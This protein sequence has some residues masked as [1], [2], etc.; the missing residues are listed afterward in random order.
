MD[1]SFVDIVN[2]FGLQLQALTLDP[3]KPTGLCAMNIYHCLSMVA[4]GSKDKNLAGFSQALGFDVGNLDK[5]LQKSAARFL[6]QNEYGC[7]LQ[8]RQLNLAS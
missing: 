5:T 6:H 7:G 3:D 2:R 8:Q 4:A 1:Q